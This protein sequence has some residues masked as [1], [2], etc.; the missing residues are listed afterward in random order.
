MLTLTLRWKF[1]WVKD[2]NAYY[3]QMTR[4]AQ[5]A[6]TDVKL[7]RY[8]MEVL[9]TM[10]DDNQRGRARLQQILLRVYNEG[11]GDAL[12]YWRAMLPHK[13]QNAL[14]TYQWS[15][16][17]TRYQRAFGARLDYFRATE[18]TRQGAPHVHALVS[19]EKEFIEREG[20]FKD[21]WNRLNPDTDQVDLVDRTKEGRSVAQS[22]GY[23]VGYVGGGMDDEK[24]TTK[25][26]KEGPR[27]MQTF[28]RYN[29]S[30]RMEAPIFGPIQR[31]YEKSGSFL[32][33]KAAK[34]AYGRMYYY[35]RKEFG[36]IVSL[37]SAQKYLMDVLDLDAQDRAHAEY[38]GGFAI[39][40]E[41]SPLHHWLKASEKCLEALQGWIDTQ[42]YQDELVSETYFWTAWDRPRSIWWT[43]RQEE[44]QYVQ[45][46][47]GTLRI[48][49]IEDKTLTPTEIRS[50]M[51]TWARAV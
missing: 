30:K 5:N 48:K 12:T 15:I 1:A 21:E 25:Y 50:R 46:N 36:K 40:L 17:M 37:Q 9:E 18:W 41:T 22:A 10:R 3:N 2:W 19:A 7:A 16:L 28:R 49:G 14:L 29:R 44:Q 47:D 11:G 45:F 13:F 20:W 4:R 23:V 6:V 35:V 38:T 26:A 51:L 24:K 39:R 42:R 8:D 33:R 43:K 27:W 32:N 34:R 31:F